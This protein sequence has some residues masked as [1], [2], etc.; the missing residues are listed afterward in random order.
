MA[1][2]A[3]HAPSSDA[4]PPSALLA[5]SELPRALAEFGTLAW[6]AGAL[7]ASAPR[8][9]GHPVLVLP[10]FMT[11]DKSTRVLRRFL[12]STGHD[13]HSWNLG[14]NLGPRAI[15]PDGEP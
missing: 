9:D 8:G 10:G 13:A 15:G 4:R 5:L 12:R 2:I 6:S 7:L 3:A 11:S 1:S 14:R